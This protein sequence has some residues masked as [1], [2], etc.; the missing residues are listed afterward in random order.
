M[1]R[2][3]TQLS[4]LGTRAENKSKHEEFYI[5]AF[6]DWH[7]T[8]FGSCY[9]V[10]ERPDPPDAIIRSEYT[11]TWVEISDI[12]WNKSWAKDVHTYSAIDEEHR[13]IPPGFH[14]GPDAQFAQ[15]FVDV[16]GNKLSKSNYKEFFDSYGPG[17]LVLPIMYPLFN[18]HSVEFMKKAWQSVQPIKDHGYFRRILLARSLQPGVSFSQWRVT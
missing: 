15:Q 14:A 12:Y 13:P 8:A 11:T 17:Y 9:E 7:R 2:T 5:N 6:I 16:V 4:G 10:V 3:P 18:H 1:D